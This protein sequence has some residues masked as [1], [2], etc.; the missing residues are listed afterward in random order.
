MAAACSVSD[1]TPVPDRLPMVTP[2]V[3]LVSTYDAPIE[4]R[5]F[6]EFLNGKKRYDE[7]F[8]KPGGDDHLTIV[9]CQRVSKIGIAF[10][11]DLSDVPRV[12][13]V[14][15]VVLKFVWTHSDRNLE[16]GKYE[17]FRGGYFPTG[18]DV[19]R[20]VD[21]LDIEYEHERA[22]GTYSVEV[23]Y[24]GQELYSD[25]F[26]FVGCKKETPSRQ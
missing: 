3:R 12:R 23:Y 17:R 25:S 1:H 10:E 18:G 14:R 5:D 11:L 6:H 8:R 13:S 22:E 20:Y 24:R 16:R 19:G 2:L 9:D 15:D 4:N 26:S 7:N 21:T